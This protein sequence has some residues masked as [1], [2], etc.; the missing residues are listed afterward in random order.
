MNQR[1]VHIEDFESIMVKD[2]LHMK[3]LIMKSPVVVDFACTEDYYGLKK[4]IYESEKIQDS[5]DH[6]LVFLGWDTTKNG[7]DYWTAQD[8]WG[9]EHGDGGLVRILR[10]GRPWF[11]NG[12]ASTLVCLPHIEE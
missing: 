7:E 3:Q 10:T 11:G 8:S 1:L 12:G 9:V 2:D 5:T 4:E 6:A